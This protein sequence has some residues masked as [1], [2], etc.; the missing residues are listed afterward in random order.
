MGKDCIQKHF[1]TFHL[2]NI[3]IY[4][5][6]H[7]YTKTAE[8]FCEKINKGDVQFNEDQFHYE[9]IINTKINTFFKINK[10]TIGKIKILEKC[11]GINLKKNI[12][13]RK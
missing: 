2:K 13:I 6:K 5:I 1:M 7:F 11:L 12:K 3:I 9:R 8:E 4:L 10:K